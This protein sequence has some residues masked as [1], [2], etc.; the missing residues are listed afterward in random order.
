M[1]HL[2][3]A[4]VCTR[5]EFNMAIAPRHSHPLWHLD[6][7]QVQQRLLLPQLEA[8]GGEAVGPQGLFLLA[9]VVVCGVEAAEGLGGFEGEGAEDVGG[10]PGDDLV[11]GLSAAVEGL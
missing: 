5:F 11:D 8:A 9:Q 7:R 3:R 2:V 10:A 4:H 1:T 6:P